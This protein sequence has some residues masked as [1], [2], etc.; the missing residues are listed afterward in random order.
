MS[1]VCRGQQVPEK[2]VKGR[3]IESAG[4]AVEARR[5]EA[6]LARQYNTGTREDNRAQ[7]EVHLSLSVAYGRGSQYTE[8]EEGGYRIQSNGGRGFKIRC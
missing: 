6:C 3:K 2:K 1:R 7:R 8:G 5:M 4:R